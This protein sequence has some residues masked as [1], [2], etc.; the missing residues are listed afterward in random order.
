MTQKINVQKTQ[1]PKPK[2]DEK[3]LGFGRYFT[4]HM[5]IMD[6]DPEKGWHDPRIVPYG[7]LTL[8]PSTMVFHYG[9]AIF[10]GLKA[11]KSADGRIFLFRPDMN[12]KRISLSNDRMSIPPIDDKFAVEATKALVSI[13][14]DWIPSEP[15]TSLYIRPFI[16][17]TDPFLGVRPS[18]TYKFIIILSPVVHIILPA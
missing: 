17:S 18:Y 8:E 11:Y 2:P 15:G 7:P 9:Q 3:N 16:F 12:M 5:F 10:E 6:Y 4:D 13:D 1:N 14:R